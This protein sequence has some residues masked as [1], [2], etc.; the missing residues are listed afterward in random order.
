MLG[1]GYKSSYGQTR[2]PKYS[3][4]YGSWKKGNTEPL[5]YKGFNWLVRIEYFSIY[6]ERNNPKV[7]SIVVGY[8]N[9]DYALKCRD[10]A[11]ENLT[12]DG[13]TIKSSA[14]KLVRV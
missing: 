4:V 11:I 12:I 2:I 5:A 6:E 3:P 7:Y 13:Y 8:Y 10:M 14:I 9:R 1:I